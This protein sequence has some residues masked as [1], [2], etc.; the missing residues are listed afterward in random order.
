VNINISVLATVSLWG[1]NESLVLDGSNEPDNS[2]AVASQIHYIN[3]VDANISA[4]VSGLPYADSGAGEGIQFHIFPNSSD[5]AAALLAIHSPGGNA[6]N[7]P[8]ALNFNYANQASPQTLTA[9][10][11]VNT[12]IHHQDIVYV[13]NLPGDLPEPGNWTAVVTYTITE[14]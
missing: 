7:P 10:T 6:Y 13:A 8:G 3:N 11:G 12:T 5:E 4:S 1:D 14:N 2:D 9:S